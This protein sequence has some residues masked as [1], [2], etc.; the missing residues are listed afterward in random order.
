MNK[1]FRT[2]LSPK[3]QEAVIKLA[4]SCIT[5][6]ACDEFQLLE[7]DTNNVYILEKNTI[8][9]KPKE[10]FSPNVDNDDDFSKI[11]S[12]SSNNQVRTTHFVN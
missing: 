3:V 1:T 8:I 4:E 10:E 6:Q 12:G 11:R 5:K 7:R 9:I 2:N